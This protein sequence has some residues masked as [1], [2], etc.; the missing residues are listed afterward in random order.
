M[1]ANPALNNW[2]RSKNY[3]K[4]YFIIRGHGQGRS[5][6]GARGAIPPQSSEKPFFQNIEIQVENCWEGGLSDSER[7]PVLEF[8]AKLSNYSHFLSKANKELLKKS[9]YFLST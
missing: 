1:S 5:Q 7:R 3:D 6:G 9:F 4:L 2:L 8:I